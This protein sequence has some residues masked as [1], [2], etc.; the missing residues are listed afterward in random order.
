MPAHFPVMALVWSFSECNLFVLVDIVT[1]PLLVLLLDI[2][3]VHA[4]NKP[5]KPELVELV[6]LTIGQTSVFAR[7]LLLEALAMHPAS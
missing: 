7:R 5:A 4:A 2:V 6:D 1:L 3:S